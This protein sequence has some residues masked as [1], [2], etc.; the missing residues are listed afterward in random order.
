MP[1]VSSNWLILVHCQ[2]A[3]IISAGGVFISCNPI[4]GGYYALYADGS[5]LWIR[6]NH[7]YQQERLHIAVWTWNKI[8]AVFIH[9]FPIF[10]TAALIFPIVRPKA[11]PTVPVNVAYCIGALCPGSGKLQ[12]LNSMSNNKHTLITASCSRRLF[13]TL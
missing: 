9:F 7:T 2:S 5:L 4:M 10:P 3:D 12:H 11:S 8:G 13:R 1:S 6:S